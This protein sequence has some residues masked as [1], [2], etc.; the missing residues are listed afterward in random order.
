MSIDQLDKIDIISTTQ[1]GE[2]I[3]H[4]AD[5][6]E[7]DNE[8]EHILLLQDKIN[9]YLQFIESGEV[10]ENY[11]NAINNKV[12]IEIIFKHEPPKSVLTY[13]GRFKEIV[14]KLGYLFFWR[15]HNTDS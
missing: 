5:H 7:W 6:L 4:I 1:K 14:D 11:P 8:K 13:F 12:A 15:L 2:V 9:A 3:L 10:F